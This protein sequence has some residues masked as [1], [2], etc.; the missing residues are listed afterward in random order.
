MKIPAKEHPRR[1]ALRLFARI[2]GVAALFYLGLLGLLYFNQESLIFPGARSRGTARARFTPPRGTDLLR[3]TTPAGETISALHGAALDAQGDL[4][5]AAKPRP[6]V[7]LFYGNG[8]WLKGAVGT[9][10]T[11]R[12]LGCDA[13]APEYV[14]YGLSSGGPGERGCCDT[15][16]TA[17]RYLVEEKGVRPE[18]VFPFGYSLGGAVAVDLAARKPVGGLVAL[19][20]FTSMDDMVGRLYPFAPTFLLRHPFRSEEK[21]RGI[22]CPVFLAHGSADALIPAEMSE[23]LARAAAGPVTRVTV[24]GAEH[25]D[26]FSTADEAFFRS[27]RAFLNVQPEPEP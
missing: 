26:L 7:V 15:A 4:L 23:R 6:T 24:E 16:D 13:L 10:Q 17:Y 3:L 25:N 14:G 9:F 5:A 2:G 11:L 12:K 22:R 19:N 1:R 18:A 27:L 20:S 8:T 21:L